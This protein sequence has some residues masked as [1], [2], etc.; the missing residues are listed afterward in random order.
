MSVQ[1]AQVPLQGETSGHLP[2][3]WSGGAGQLAH[4]VSP[5]VVHNIVFADIIERPVRVL[6]DSGAC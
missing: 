1:A 5:A 4:G 2:E 3:Q 6:F